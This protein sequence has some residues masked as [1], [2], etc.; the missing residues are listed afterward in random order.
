[1]ACKHFTTQES[2]S[3][4]VFSF[5]CRYASAVHK[6]DRT[7]DTKEWGLS[8]CGRFVAKV[9]SGAEV[10]NDTREDDSIGISGSKFNSS[11]DDPTERRQ[12]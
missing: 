4:L 10:W 3:L 2:V 12:S 6:D 7:L 5:H 8:A 9:I 11:P 1:M